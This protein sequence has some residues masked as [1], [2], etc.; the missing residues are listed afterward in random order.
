[1]DRDR[2]YIAGPE[3]MLH[4]LRAE[5]GKVIWKKDMVTY[6]HVVQ[7]FF[8]V[9]ST[10]VIE[11]DLLITQVG[12]SPKDVTDERPSLELQGLDSGVV[13]FDKY[14]G[15]VKYHV[16]DELASYSVAGAGDDRRPPL[17]L[18]L[19]ARRSDRLRAVHRES[20]LS[21]PLAGADPGERQRHPT[22]W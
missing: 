10:P 16:T 12:G 6:F 15:A 7:N 19:R 2:V 14:T 11:G 8:G 18:H 5:D 21:L 22:P 13:A 3:G 4:C 9:G 20:G 1:M 17:V